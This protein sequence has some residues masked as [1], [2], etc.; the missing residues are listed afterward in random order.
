VRGLLAHPVY[1]LRRAK[2]GGASVPGPTAGE[3]ADRGPADPHAAPSGDPP[4]ADGAEPFLVGV[5][6]GTLSADELLQG[7][8]A[9]VH[10]QTANYKE[11]ARRL[12]LN[13]KTVRTKVEAW[14]QRDPTKARA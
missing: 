4:S 11:T 1:T 9:H 10:A 13:W 6:N 12:R 2:T 8:C 5:R 3:A 14:T 7:Y